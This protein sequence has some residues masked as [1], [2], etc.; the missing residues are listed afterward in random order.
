[1]ESAE[2][3][4]D[5]RL[6]RQLIVALPIELGRDDWLLLLRG[7][8]QTECVDKGMC[9]DF[10]IHD[11]DGHNP[12]AHIMLTMRPLDT[13]GKWQGKTQKEYLCRKADEER[14]FTAQ[15]FL[16]AKEDGWEKQYKHKNAAGVSAWLTPTQ[17]AHEPGWE[18]CS[19]QPK[20]AKFGRQN[21]LCARWNSPE[22]LLDW[23]EA[24]ADAV[25]RVLEE[26]QQSSRVTHLSHAALG[27]D[28]Q[29]TVH[30][31]SQARNIELQGI[32]ADRCELNRQ[33]RADNKL[34]RELKAQL[35]KLSKTVENTVEH[36]AETLERLRS[37]LI[38]LQY[39][40]LVNHKQADTWKRQVN[41]YRP[42]LQ[43]YHAVTQQLVDKKS[44][45]EQL[46]TNCN[47]VSPLQIIQRRQ[48]AE[49]IAALTEE[50]EEL[51]SRQA[52]ILHNL[53]CKNNGE[54]QRFGSYLDK[55]EEMQARLVIQRETL[56]QQ[57]SENMAQ[58]LETANAILPKDLRAV[59]HCRAALR[60]DIT[61]EREYLL[62]DADNFDF[63]AMQY[64][65][66][67][68]DAQIKDNFF[69]K[70]NASHRHT[71]RDLSR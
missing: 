28:E 2:K 67:F 59:R 53:D 37:S 64:A 54:A 68:V 70:E 57:Y 13:H 44:E 8:I 9:A 4:K 52:M 55:L 56:M 29:P 25:N 17:A 51:R 66:R 62:V 27:L 33:I 21:P 63:S 23:R 40:L 65:E 22:Q 11:P 39:R 20:A 34:L 1:M 71:N 38:M 61:A 19:K 12:H 45:Q 15:E 50:I 16:Q 30:E 43:D 69:N 36:I 3:T 49:Q 10:A 42:I 7:F 18:R 26:K 32:K 58:Y 5:S 14:G 35:A 46:Q 6:A 31:G 41:Y 60:P 48:L 24:W 47:A